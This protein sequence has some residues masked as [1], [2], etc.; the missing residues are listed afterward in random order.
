MNGAR[1][2]IETLLAHGV[3]VCFAN[4]GTS[5]MH[6]VQAMDA[7]PGFRGV[8]GLFEGVCTGAADGYGRMRGHPAATLL[9]LGAG[10]GNG[11]ANL[12]NARRA[13]TPI[14]NLIGEHGRHHVPFD[15]PLTADIP[16]IARP[17]SAWVRTSGTPEQLAQDGADAVLATLTARPNP[18]GAIATLVIPADCAWGE[19]AGRLA[20][21]RALER[22]RNPFDAAAVPAAAATLSARSVLLLD[23]N[24]LTQRGLA[25]VA[26]IVEKTGTAVFTATFPARVEGG[27]DVYPVRRLPYFPEQIAE[28][29]AEV[30]GLVLA[31]A[32][33]PVSF[34]A[35][36]SLP[37][38]LVPEAVTPCVLARRDQDAA[39]ALEAL[40]DELDAPA[41]TATGR[42]AIA[43]VDIERPSGP[44]NTGAVSTL[45]AATAPADAIVAVDS[46]GGGAAYTPMQR[47]VPHSWLNL[48]GGAIGQGGP[49]AVGAAIACPD[50][51][52]YALLGD[53]G[54]MYTNQFLWTA[55]R[56]QL[57]ITVVIYSNRAYN[58]LEVEYRRL[59]VNEIG[60]DAGSLF[61]LD[62]PAIDWVMLARA[63]GVDAVQADTCEGFEAALLQ[64]A[65][66]KG[67]FLI[68]AVLSGRR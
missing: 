22:Q 35:Y 24:A 27:P 13:D 25:A 45:L 26:R 21:A 58:I 37:S 63:Q 19:G 68:E 29:L 30:E 14:L 31:G 48:T 43:Q 1:S 7:V 6:L 54:A 15:A 38:S 33:A 50:R 42:H 18:E 51:K 9:H 57:D 17:V 36:P 52:V 61:N 55:A 67:P 53:G 40:A 60:A 2:L 47:S 46:G 20:P 49:V 5:E 62:E 23:G 56:E 44:L 4:P 32:Q 41:I 64:A 66:R 12:H 8:L 3:E 34:F 39:A 59:G 28:A 11:I 10:L 16:G 65:E